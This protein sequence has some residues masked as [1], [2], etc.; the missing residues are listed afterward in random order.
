MGSQ[1]RDGGLRDRHREAR[2][3]VALAGR[4]EVVTHA[5]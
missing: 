1:P 3:D 2:S 5:R 4:A